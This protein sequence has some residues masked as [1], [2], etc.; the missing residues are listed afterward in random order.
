[1]GFLYLDLP[2]PLAT[3]GLEVLV[4]HAP[5]MRLSHAAHRMRGSV[6]KRGR[7]W[8]YVV[9]VGPRLGHLRSR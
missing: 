1:M 4:R 2:G 7:T 6:V 5:A 3:D 9:D 8:T